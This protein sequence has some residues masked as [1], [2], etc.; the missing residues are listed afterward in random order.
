M[1]ARRRSVTSVPALPLKRADLVTGSAWRF[2]DP[3]YRDRSKLKTYELKIVSK[4]VPAG[5]AQGWY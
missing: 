4:R 5:H 1:T 2:A 3:D